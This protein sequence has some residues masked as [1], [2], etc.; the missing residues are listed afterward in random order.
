MS[1]GLGIIKAIKIRFS[2]YRAW[3]NQFIVWVNR[4]TLLKK[5]FFLHRL[6]KYSFSATSRVQVNRF[7]LLKI[8]FFLKIR[9]PKQRF[10]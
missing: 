5:W 6:S 9:F 3:V 2:M 1:C 4:F 7:T 10:S 8:G